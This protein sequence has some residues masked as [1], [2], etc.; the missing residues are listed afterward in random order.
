MTEMRGDFEV[1]ELPSGVTVYYRDS[2]HAYFDRIEER[3]EGEW[4]GP[5]DARLPSPSA[6][7]DVFSLNKARMMSNAAARAGLEW[8]VRKDK[9]AEEGTNVHQHVLEILAAGDRIPS[10]A[11]VSEAERGYAQ[12]VIAWWSDRLPD[13]IVSEQVVYSAEHRFAG[14]VDLIATIN[15]RR[16]AVDLKTGFVGEGAHAQL[17]GYELA[18]D[19]S[20]FGPIEATLILKVFENGTYAE[21][22]GLAV[23]EDFIDALKVYRRGKALDKGVKE[24]IKRAL[25]QA[26]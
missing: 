3:K 10:L 25:E 21:Y 14:R 20:G 9:R 4:V 1:H 19:E 22:E 17:A 5:K 23:P 13:P 18:A 15:G 7:G 2:Q 8:F 26:A 16:T 6:V 11:D 12:G 24:Q